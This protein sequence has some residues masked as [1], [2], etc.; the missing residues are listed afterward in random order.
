MCKFLQTGHYLLDDSGSV[1]RVQMDDLAVFVSHKN[2]VCPARTCTSAS[3]RMRIELY[4]TVLWNTKLWAIS[5]R[6][7]EAV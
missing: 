3:A 7:V 2:I 6:I 5:R 1:E 4:C